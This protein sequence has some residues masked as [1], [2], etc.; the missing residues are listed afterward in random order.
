MNLRTDIT[1]PTAAW[2]H[3]T[4]LD[5]LYR[6]RGLDVA[7][8]RRWLDEVATWTPLQRD[9]WRLRKLG[10]ILEHAWRQV[11]FYREYWGD[12]GVEFFRPA[13][14]EELA[15]YP[16]LTK[17]VFRA[18]AA[19]IVPG[20]LAAIPHLAKHTGGT[21][22]E[23]VHYRLDLAQ[24]SLMQAF[25]EWGWAQAGHVRGEPA[26]VMA[27]GSLIAADTTLALR[28]R[29]FAERR[30]FL[31]GVHM[32]DSLARS[33]HARLQAY[34]PTVLYGYPSVLYLFTR[35]LRDRG[36]T[37][38]SVRAVITT[39]EM[40][41]PHYRAGIESALHCRVFD[42]LGCNDGGFESFECAEHAGFH[43]N[44]TQAVLEVDSPAP[45]GTGRLLVTNLWN[46]STPF[47]RYENGDLARL[48]SAPCACG[49]AYPR[50]AAIEGRTADIL[51]FANGRSLSGPA[52]TLIFAP[53][54]IEGWQVVQTA[55]DGLEVRLRQAPPLEARATQRITAILSHHLGPEVNVAIRRVDALEV[56]AAGK[57]KPVWSE[58]PALQTATR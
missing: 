32:D 23:P 15:R 51:S 24:W 46:R 47:I 17:A 33:H 52:L 10:E 2:F 19:R 29:R 42:N 21:T 57:R 30:L 53:L 55:P 27:G 16:V 45:D 31:F 20:N 1:A 49:S 34:A 22:G 8:R 3:R 6:T 58:V 50:I 26:A 4:L 41:H 5:G 28:L 14:L 7:A 13:A 40:L 44:D 36:L 43:F 35:L 11:P 54:A 12:H 38:P 18:N 25:H 37:L 48:D 39:A 56:T 9:A